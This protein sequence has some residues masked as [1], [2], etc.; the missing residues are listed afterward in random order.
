M[1]IAKRWSKPSKANKAPPK[2]GVYEFGD[3][4]G[5]VIKIGEG[6]DLSDRIPSALAEAGRQVKG[7]RWQEAKRGK[8]LLKRKCCWN[9]KRNTENYRSLIKGS[10]SISVSTGCPSS[11][12]DIMHL[13]TMLQLFHY[14]NNSDI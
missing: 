5:E 4:K 7:I 11:I 12:I 8:K 9:S 14:S 13:N 6:G 3:A 10:N 2:S 1:P